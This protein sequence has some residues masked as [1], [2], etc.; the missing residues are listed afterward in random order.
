[1]A[2][3]T[4]TILT[5]GAIT[6][7]NQVIVNKQPIDWK[8]PIA[9][10]LAAGMFALAEK[11]WHDGAVMLAYVALVTTLFVRVDPKTPSPLESFNNWYQKG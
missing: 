10:G 2:D 1:M 6:M 5:I 8:V 9:T 4:G 11:G 7:A 3:T